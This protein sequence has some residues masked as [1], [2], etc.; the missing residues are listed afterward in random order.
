[1][2]RR[3]FIGYAVAS[4]ISSLVIGGVT[5]LIAAETGDSGASCKL[6]GSRPN[7]IMFLADDLS[8]RDMSCFGQEEF[9]TPH[10]DR[11]ANNG[12]IFSNAYAATNVCAPS[13][14]GLM[15][16]LHMGHCPIRLLGRRDA[17]G[18]RPYLSDHETM[19]DVLKQ[20]GYATGV[21]GKW[22]MGEPETPGMPHLQGFE[23]SLCFDHS[24]P[25]AVK[26]AQ[27]TYP[28]R[29]WLNG[30][31]YDLEENQGFRLHHPDNH[32]DEEGRFVPGGV[33]DPSKAEYGEDIYLKKAL[34]F[35]REPRDE[36]FF[37]YYATPLTHA[38]WPKELR[39]LKDK[40]APWTMNQKRWAGQVKQMDRSLGTIVE[41]LRKQNIEDNTVLIF[42]SDHGYS[43]WSYYGSLGRYEDDPVLHNKGPWKGGKHICTNG[44][45]IVPFI[46][47]GPGL[48]TAG[49]TD[50][51][52]AFYDLKETFADIAG[53]ASKK[54]GD[55]VSIAPLL[56]GQHRLYPTRDF[57][58]WENGHFSRTGQS[59]LLN[60][61]FFAVRMRPGKPVELYDVFKDPGCEN[62]IAGTYPELVKRAESLF[63]SEHEPHP[64]FPKLTKALQK[65]N[66]QE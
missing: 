64:W 21:V 66:E 51:A 43:E 17:E 11:L 23:M 31:S 26:S 45:M 29:L 47:W 46:V 53:G 36:P 18:G 30:K 15:T 6:S 42:T 40:K 13:R 54:S 9:S 44:G 27:Y 38:H 25:S 35:I 62:N 58:Y 50:R 37:L 34:E 5:Q 1:M 24:H 16:G 7:I 41:E 63:V 57:L 48:V 59:V 28:T 22:H 14:A 65:Y 32:Y 8:Y 49:K 39:G 2:K 56:C 20:A 10:V 33:R 4:I 19:A 3:E 61:R 55:G 60:E 12:M 52:V